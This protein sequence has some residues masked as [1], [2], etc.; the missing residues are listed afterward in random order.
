VPNS[1]RE[2]SVALGATK[3]QTV[4]RI[5][6][7]SALPGVL[8][9]LIIGVAK[10]AGETAPVMWTAVTFTAT[11]VH[12][13]YGV[14]PDVY[15]PVNNLCYHLL[16]LIYFL[17]AWDVEEK[18]WGTALVLMALVLCINMLAILV[19]NYYMKKISW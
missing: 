2:G 13:F 4:K 16:Q 18:A 7:P 14:V 10:A 19:R 9:G 5:V 1:L 11:P 8:T 15:Q 3:W 17:G 6:L 12:K